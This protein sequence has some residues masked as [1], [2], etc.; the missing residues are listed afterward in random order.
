MPLV[1][2]QK[3]RKKKCFNWLLWNYIYQICNSE[4]LQTCSLKWPF[5][6]CSEEGESLSL[7]SKL[8]ALPGPSQLVLFARDVTQPLT[9]QQSGIFRGRDSGLA[10][11]WLLLLDQQHSRLHVHNTLQFC[12]ALQL[13]IMLIREAFHLSVSIFHSLFPGRNEA[14]RNEARSTS[15][16][17]S[18]LYYRLQMNRV[19]IQL[20]VFFL[21]KLTVEN[22]I[23]CVPFIFLQTDICILL[24]DVTS[25]D[26]ATQACP[27]VQFL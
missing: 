3:K 1:V 11:I 18:S 7:L 21:L 13:Q 5:K 26:C 10:G 16:Q 25:G 15:W 19:D 20:T 17:N 9:A 27:F 8:P 22:R 23:S 2:A 4:C 6:R 12:D 24:A 14:Q